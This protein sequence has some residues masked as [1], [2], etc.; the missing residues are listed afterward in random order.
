MMRLISFLLL[1]LLLLI[2]SVSSSTANFETTS[3]NRL[4]VFEAFL[5]PACGLCQSAAPAIDQLAAEYAGQPVLFLEYNVDAA[6][7]SRYGRWWASHEGTGPVMLPLVMASSGQQISNG[8]VSYYNTY[9]AMVE[10]ERIRSPQAH[11]IAYYRRI[12]NRL[13]FDVRVTNLSGTTLSW[14]NSATVHAVVYEEAQIGLTGRYVRQA[15]ATPIDVPLAPGATDH[16]MLMTEEID[17]VDWHKIHTVVMVDYR[18]NS[19]GPYDMLQAVVPTA[20]PTFA[21]R[22]NPMIF[23]VDDSTGQGN[24]LQLSFQGAA[25]LEWEAS[26][27]ASWLT[28]LPAAGNLV[29]APIASVTV[30]SLPDGWLEGSVQFMATD[31]AGG[32][33]Y[34]D[35]PVR[36]YYGPLA[37]LYLPVVQREAIFQQ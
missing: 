37:Y 25:W 1:P 33:F 8:P 19:V 18:P 26:T 2:V 13:Q 30:G 36:V 4:V 34:E 11:L 15:V 12:D 10:A 3:H 21:V 14:Q 17:A 27:T 23:L 22:P 24:T 9:K 6:P 5:R 16:F 35:V 7:G 31:D 28:I 29:D 20:S 32:E